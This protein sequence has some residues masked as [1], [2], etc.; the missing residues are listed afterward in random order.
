MGDAEA[1]VGVI[2]IKQWADGEKRGQQ[3]VADEEESV[4]NNTRARHNLSSTV[5]DCNAAA[6]IWD[7]L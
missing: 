1:G 3:E 2:R 4:M 5:H 6:T 7:A